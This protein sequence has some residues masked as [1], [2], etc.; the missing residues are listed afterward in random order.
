MKKVALFILVAILSVSTVFAASYGASK[1]DTLSIGLNLGSNNGVV[2]NYGMGKFDLE[3]IVGFSLF[4]RNMDIEIAANYALF[5]IAEMADFAGSM[6]FTVGAEGIISTDFKDFG[7][8]AVVPLKLTYTFP[9]VPVSLY[10]SIAPGVMFNIVPDF[11]PKFY[12]PVS[13]GATYNF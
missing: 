4:N 12:I 11:D 7:V 10:F 3:G 13:L 6:P 8:G 1:K 5:D 9:K 2:I